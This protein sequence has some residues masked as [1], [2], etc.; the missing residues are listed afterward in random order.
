[1][2]DLLAVADLSR[3]ESGLFL[4]WFALALLLQRYVPAT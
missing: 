2:V 4:V 3:L 1:L